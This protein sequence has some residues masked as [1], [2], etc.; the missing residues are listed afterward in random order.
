MSYVIQIAAAFGAMFAVAPYWK[1]TPF[2]AGP[3]YIALG[4]L[5]AWICAH[6]GACIG[7]KTT[8]NE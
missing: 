1:D 3:C 6:I 4:V 5:A 8:I 2:N 7:R